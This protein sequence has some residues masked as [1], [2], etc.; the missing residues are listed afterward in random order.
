MD[1]FVPFLVWPAMIC[2]P[3]ILTTNNFYEQVFPES[4]YDTAPRDFWNNSKGVW[5]SPVGLSLGLATV[6]IGQI[7]MLIYFIAWKAGKFG[8]KLNPV[9]KVGAPPY[10]VMEGLKVHLAQPEGF[11]LLGSYLCI[12]WMSGLMP[13]SYYSFSGGINWKHVVLQ[14]LCQDAVQTIMHRLEHIVSP[15]FYRAT[16]KP[17]HRFTNPKLF[18]AFN[19]SAGDTICMILFPLVITSRF[20]D[21]NV[22]SYMVFGSVL[23]NWLTLIHSEYVHPWDSMFKKLGFG[24]AADHHVHHK[25]F[26]FNYGHLFM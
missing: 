23:A 24:T 18:D 25:L 9:Q 20:V 2:L 10:V 8:G 26:V 1:T 13:A 3:L 4:W 7:F 19:G 17:H 22:W 14:L 6:A 5:P 11:V 21:A 12:Y 16:H 15:S